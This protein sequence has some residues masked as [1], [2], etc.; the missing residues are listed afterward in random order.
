MLVLFDGYCGLCNKSVDF[1]IRID[2]THEFKF[3]PLQGKKAAS[4][5]IPHL[6]IND[7]E[8]ILVW[9][10]ERLHE[11]SQAVFFI[12]KKLPYPWKLFSIFSFVPL[13]ISNFVYEQIAKSRYQWFGKTKTCR[14]PSYE[15]RELFFD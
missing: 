15:E 2:K 10:G 14:I 13:S 7:P 3:A 12:L 11:K 4:I 9:D 6:K 1:L 5:G 8:S